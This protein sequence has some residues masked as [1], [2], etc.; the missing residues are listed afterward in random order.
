MDISNITLAWMM[1]QLSPFIDFDP[2][3]LSEQYRLSQEY[4]RAANKPMRPWGCGE[5]FWFSLKVI[6]L[7]NVLIFPERLH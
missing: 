7:Y 5:S 3:Y 6:G 1:A 4:F 2:E